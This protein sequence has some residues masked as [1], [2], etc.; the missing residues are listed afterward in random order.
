MTCPRCHGCV[1]TQY[2]ET[3][4]LSCGWYDNPPVSVPV[5]MARHCYDCREPAVEGKA[6][7]QKC[8]DWAMNYRRTQVRA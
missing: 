8:L 2:E 1:I 5:F 3:R 4:C 7:C 6:R